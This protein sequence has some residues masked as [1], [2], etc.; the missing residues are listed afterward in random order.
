MSVLK[1]LLGVRIFK[2][3]KNHSSYDKF[4]TME[5]FLHFES[6]CTACCFAISGCLVVYLKS[7][8]KAARQASFWRSFSFC[9]IINRQGVISGGAYPFES[10]ESRCLIQ[11]NSMSLTLEPRKH[12]SIASSPICSRNTAASTH[13]LAQH[14]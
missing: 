2:P 9:R 4:N 14:K 6:L 1:A 3:L 5:A 10:S 11:L 8:P 7:Q 13:A 12:P